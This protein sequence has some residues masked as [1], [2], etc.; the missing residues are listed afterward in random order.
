MSNYYSGPVVQND[1]SGP[2][3]MPWGLV[4]NNEIRHFIF[5]ATGVMVSFRAKPSRG[6]NGPKKIELAGCKARLSE[7]W[8]LALAI[9]VRPNDWDLDEPVFLAAGRDV[10][11]GC[12][13][14]QTHPGRIRP[15]DTLRNQPRLVGWY[16][17]LRDNKWEIRS[18]EDWVDPYD[19]LPQIGWAPDDWLA[20]AGWWQPQQPAAYEVALPADDDAVALIMQQQQEVQTP[21]EVQPEEEYEPN[22]EDERRLLRQLQSDRQELSDAISASYRALSYGEMMDEL[23][24]MA[25]GHGLSVREEVEQL[26]VQVGALRRLAEV[27]RRAIHEAAATA[28]DEVAARSVRERVDAT[29]AQAETEVL[30]LLSE[31]YH[32]TIH[33][34]A[35]AAAGDI[36]QA[37]LYPTIAAEQ[38]AEIAMAAE[39]ALEAR[40][41]VYQAR[42]DA[43]E[44]AAV[45]AAAGDPTG[46]HGRPDSLEEAQ[47]L[48][49]QPEELT[50]SHVAPP[51][52][53]LTEEASDLTEEIIAG[54]LAERRIS[55]SV[56]MGVE[57]G[58]AAQ[59]ALGESETETR[60][61]PE[62]EPVPLAETGA[63]MQMQTRRRQEG[64]AGIRTAAELAATHP[65]QSPGRSNEPTEAD[66][67]SETET[68]RE[69]EGEPDPAAEAGAGMPVAQPVAEP[70]AEALPEEF[71]EPQ[72]V[73]ARCD[74]CGATMFARS[75]RFA[76]P[77]Q[78]IN[79]KR[80]V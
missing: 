14:W 39:D 79:G 18:P 15:W 70:V 4:M 80:P 7:A 52:S 5:Q 20:D 68:R 63:A 48:V 43:E 24:D 50:L 22:G 41:D 67:E 12:P 33:E 57:R 62:P 49:L 2:F 66:S 29:P 77:H 31:A 8:W 58:M 72:S 60:P 75:I 76:I 6:R 13:Q 23:A 55:Q 10:R 65:R 71:P 34:A 74:K 53:G 26:Q 78:P 19:P 27:Y 42:R 11:G 47:L 3:D 28:A 44:A 32:R 17:H 51:A 16:W 73:P 25:T 30:R 9:G 37:Q 69:A 45:A 38:A 46:Q 1:H 54:H 56:M 64:Y 36:P 61:D 40:R 59:L 21:Q 35:A